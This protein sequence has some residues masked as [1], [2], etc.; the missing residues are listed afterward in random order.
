MAKSIGPVLRQQWRA[1]SSLPAGKWLFSRLLGL[2]VP[3]TGTLGARI[4]TLQPGRCIILLPDKRKVRN[5]LHSIHAI[6][7]CNLGEMVTGLALMNSLPDKTR[8]ILTGLSINY[9][10]KARGLLT[11]RCDCD[12]PENNSQQ[13]L[14]LSG[15]ITDSDNDLVSEI[16]ARWLIGPEKDKPA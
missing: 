1:L 13:E 2:T 9:L 14:L 4:Q 7:L 10:K 12:I 6:A 8:G 15:R 3:Y 5:H 11:A 16:Q